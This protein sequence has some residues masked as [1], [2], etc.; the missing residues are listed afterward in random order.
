MA[1]KRAR[2][3]EQELHY[4][5]RF[6]KLDL[7]GAALQTAIPWGS[8]V[9]LAWLVSNALE[10][11]A[12]QETIADIGINVLGN[13]GINDGLAYALAAGTIFYGNRERRLRREVTAR[14][15]ARTTEL[16]E[17]L[18]SGRSSSGITTHGTTRPGD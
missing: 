16:E 10:S 17:R 5:Y 6:R 14:L 13:V 1:A 7:I 11:L 4:N 8:L 18:D 2:Q 12:G 9:F 15:T 3:S